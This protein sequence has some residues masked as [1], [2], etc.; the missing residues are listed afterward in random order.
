VYCAN[1]RSQQE[2]RLTDLAGLTADVRIDSG[3]AF[4]RW[5]PDSEPPQ[6]YMIDLKARGVVP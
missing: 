1:V 4:F 3:R 6:I 2:W 5:M